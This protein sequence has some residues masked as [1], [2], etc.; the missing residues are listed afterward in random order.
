MRGFSVTSMENIALWHERDISHSSAERITLPD[1]CLA[2]DYVLNVF[3]RVMTGL[4]VYPENMRRNLDLTKGLVFSQR[5]LLAII[6]KGLDRQKAYG[7]VQRNSMKAWQEEVSLFSLL[8]SDREITAV[9]S[10]KELK[11]LFN[12]QYYLR[13]VDNV[14]A[15]LGLEPEKRKRRVQTGRIK[16][17]DHTHY[18]N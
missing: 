8:K 5:V 13:Y 10:T 18:R 1:S 12:Y 6:D 15:R 14:F 11:E 3:T 16:S 17:H 9:L 7:I 4:N 2:L